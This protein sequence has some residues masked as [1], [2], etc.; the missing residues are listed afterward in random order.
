MDERL[1]EIEMC[2][3]KETEWCRSCGETWPCDV[4]AL[5][6]EVRRLRRENHLLNLSRGTPSSSQY[7]ELNRRRVLD[8]D[9]RWLVGEG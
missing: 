2:H 4:V 9:G 7:A 1:D 8:V 5:L 3:I 6:A